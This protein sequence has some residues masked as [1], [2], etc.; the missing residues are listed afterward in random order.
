MTETPT[1]K[2]TQLSREG[3]KTVKGTQLSHEVVNKRVK[4]CL[5]SKNK[6][7][8]FTILTYRQKIEFSNIMYIV[9]Y[10]GVGTKFSSKIVDEVPQDH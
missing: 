1:V 5:L 8:N 9:T 4:G 10:R 3:I 6:K 2:G 7:T